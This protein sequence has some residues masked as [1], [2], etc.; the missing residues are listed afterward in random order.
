MFSS[1]SVLF[2]KICDKLILYCGLSSLSMLSLFYLVG[3]P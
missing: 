3:T 1:V 2:Y